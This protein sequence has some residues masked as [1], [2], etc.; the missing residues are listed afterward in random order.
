MVPLVSRVLDFLKAWQTP[1]NA[2]SERLTPV[3]ERDPQDVAIGI[4]EPSKLN[5]KPAARVRVFKPSREPSG[6]WALSTFCVD[7]L[8]DQ[9]RWDLLGQYINP[10]VA[11]VELH[12]NIFRKAGLTV[13]AD[14]VPERHVNILDW[15]DDEEAR[16][17]TSIAQEA[18]CKAQ[19]LVVR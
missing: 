3:A 9:G 10:L 5:K 17:S 13:D 14:W 2:G 1:L 16:T 8:D 11:R 12:T 19:R 18:L 15:P 6:V 4:N 7:Q